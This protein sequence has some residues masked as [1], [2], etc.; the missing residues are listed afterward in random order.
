M[1]ILFTDGVSSNFG[2]SLRSAMLLKQAGIG[3]V[4]V[5]VGSYLNEI[6]I[7]EMASD[8]KDS[9]VIAVSSSV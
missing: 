1:V 2:R 7:N 4:I 6:E 5:T 8:P 3:I 9:N